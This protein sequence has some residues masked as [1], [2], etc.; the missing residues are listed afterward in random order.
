M[1]DIALDCSGIE[2]ALAAA[3]H[4]VR[5]GGTLVVVGNPPQPGT[6]LPLAWMQRQ[7]FSLVTAF[8]YA[9]EFPAA[10]SLAAT[11]RVELESL[12]TARFPLEHSADALRTA[13]TDPAQLK[14]VIEPCPLGPLGPR[15]P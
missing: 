15:G 11:G 8:R 14:V 7:E 13:L 12:I 6:T 10:V 4:A 3:V 2:A 5:P 9:G 1:F